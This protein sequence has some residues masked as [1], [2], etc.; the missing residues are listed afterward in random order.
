MICF[1]V[2]RVLLRCKNSF[3]LNNPNNLKNLT[4]IV[5]IALSFA[6]AILECLVSSNSINVG[7]TI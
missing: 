1:D 2:F 6:L 5:A 3:A 7:K 4:L